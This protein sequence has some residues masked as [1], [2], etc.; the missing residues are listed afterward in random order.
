MT[1]V[2]LICGTP[3]PGP[4]AHDTQRRRAQPKADI[5]PHTYEPTSSGTC[6]HCPLPAKHPAHRIPTITI[7][8]ELDER[9]LGERSKSSSQAAA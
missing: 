2:W 6:Q 7:D 3:A 8:A 1:G 4:C 5:V 9:V